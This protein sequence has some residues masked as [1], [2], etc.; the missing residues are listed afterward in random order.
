ME[1]KINHIIARVLSG[2]ASLDDTLA[3]SDWLNESLENRKSFSQIK[4]YWD[5]EIAQKGTVNHELLL[6]KIREKISEQN[7]KANKMRFLRTIIPVAA[8]IAALIVMFF[9]LSYTHHVKENLKEKIQNYYTYLTNDNKSFF[10]LDDGTKITLNKHSRLTFSDTYGVNNRH[11]KLEGEAF[12]EVVKDTSSPFEVAF[13]IETE[14]DASIKV[15]GT[16]FSVKID[17]DSERVIA[18]L[19]EGAI[20]FETG[21]Q[22]IMMTP[23]QQLEFIYSD[24]QI[25]L[26]IVDAENEVAWKDGILKYK[27]IAFTDM[28]KELEKVYKVSILI[29][30]QRYASPSIMVSG[31]F[32]EIQSLD[33]VL[34]VISR[35]MPIKWTKKDGIYYIK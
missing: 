14:N 5:A 2:E 7:R 24:S 34:A 27:A 17:A 15:L 10:T 25:D 19:V 28:V 3:L 31:G 30:N 6:K 21:D 11:V 22:K 20:R 35:S 13:E 33:Q 1:N 16:V 9:S 4:I 23:N 29:E 8:S 18:T 26:R 12:F 32:D